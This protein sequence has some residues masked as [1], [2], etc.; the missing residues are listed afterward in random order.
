MPIS[1]DSL[2]LIFIVVAVSDSY[3]LAGALSATAAIVMSIAMPFWSGFSDR[4]GQRALIIRVVPFKVFGIILF[5][6]LVLNDAPTWTWFASIIF[7]EASSINLG[8][9]VRR[10]WLHVL[11]PDKTSTSEDEGNRH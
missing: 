6:V 11:S 4:I 7:A 5:M 2:A 1:M 9:L 8:G 3:A 10:R